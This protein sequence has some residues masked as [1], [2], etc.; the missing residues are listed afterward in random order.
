MKHAGRETRRF[1]ALASAWEIKEAE[2]YTKLISY[3]HCQDRKQYEDSINDEGL[4]EGSGDVDSMKL[5]NHETYNDELLSCSI[6]DAQ[7]SQLQD[8]VQCRLRSRVPTDDSVA[9]DTTDIEADRSED[10]LDE[11]NG[12]TVDRNEGF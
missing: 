8:E 2:H 1:R 10:L 6:S 12:H 7:L 5:L 3:V 9:G 11:S 4:Y